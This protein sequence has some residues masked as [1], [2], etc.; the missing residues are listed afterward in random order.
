MHEN[1]YPG[2]YCDQYAGKY[3]FFYFDQDRQPDIHPDRDKYS[4]NHKYI[5]PNTDFYRDSDCFIY[6]YKN[7]DFNRYVFCD[8]NIYQDCEPDIYADKDKYAGKYR[9]QYADKHRYF[10]RDENKYCYK[11]AD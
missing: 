8:I 4:G 5:Y 10:Y 3:Q 1:K 2:K 11:H 7:I 6:G 9:D